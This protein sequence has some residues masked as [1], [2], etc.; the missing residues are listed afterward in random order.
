MVKQMQLR[1]IT[2]E[3]GTGLPHQLV[4][5]QAAAARCWVGALGLLQGAAGC[6][7]SQLWFLYF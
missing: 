3:E 4:T 5:P 6:L 1:F 2:W 7:S